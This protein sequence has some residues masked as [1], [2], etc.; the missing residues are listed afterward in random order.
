M[1]RPANPASLI[2]GLL[3]LMLGGVALWNAF[4][5]IDWNLLRVIA[6]LSLVAVGVLGLTLSR[7]RT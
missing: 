3:G 5:V 7:H 4:G 1:R 2:V 6:P